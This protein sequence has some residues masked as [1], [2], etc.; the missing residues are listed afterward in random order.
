MKRRPRPAPPL[1]AIK[2]P[3]AFCGDPFTILI[4]RRGRGNAAR[5]QTCSQA[6]KQALYRER[7]KL[8]AG[9][10]AIDAQQPTGKPAAALRRRAAF[11]ARHRALNAPP[12]KRAKRIAQAIEAKETRTLLRRR[13]GR[14][15]LHKTRSARR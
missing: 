13:G 1:P 14:R 12:A 2:R 8:T 15:R 6:C 5:R 11:L 7:N 9:P 4:T 10:P 3:C